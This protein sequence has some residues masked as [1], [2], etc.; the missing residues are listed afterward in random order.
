MPGGDSRQE[1]GYEAVA[2]DANSNGRREVTPLKRCHLREI[3][4]PKD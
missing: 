1:G 3:Q 4:D 2:G